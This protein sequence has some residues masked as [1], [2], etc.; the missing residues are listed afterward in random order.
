MEVNLSTAMS[1]TASASSGS[2]QGQGTS[3]ADGQTG[4]FG[5]LL[6]AAGSENTDQDEKQATDPLLALMAAL[7]GGLSPVMLLGQQFQAQM[8]SAGAEVVASAQGLF[9]N[10]TLNGNSVQLDLRNVSLNNGEFANL[11]Q[12]FGASS[13]LM[14]VLLEQPLGQPG[15]TLSAHPEL[16]ADLGKSMSQLMQTV[17]AQPQLVAAEPQ[18]AQLME[19]V[20]STLKGGQEQTSNGGG[21]MA[22]GSKGYGKMLASL[23][24]HSLQISATEQSATT[25][26][27]AANAT[28]VD[29]V[30]QHLQTG[31]MLGAEA[32]VTDAPGPN[33]DQTAPNN[34]WLSNS[35]LAATPMQAQQAMN[36]AKAEPV[37]HV[38][39]DQFHNEFAGLLVKRAAL[40]ETPGSQEFRI[41]LQPHGLGEI[42]VRVQTIGNQISLHFSADTTAAKGLLD[43]ELGSLKAQLQAQGIQFN[44]IE[45]TTSNS[46]SELAYGGMPQ[47]RG[48]SQQYQEQDGRNSKESDA[49]PFSIEALSDL[50]E[51]EPIPEEDGI[52]VSA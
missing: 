36:R 39:A 27:Q 28:Q 29:G 52:D 35:A 40:I 50:P 26:L 31:A 22:K 16:F 47:E 9:V 34:L 41:L 24:T 6:Q 33:E 13:A 42:E 38:H 23:S 45:V 2:T 12:D 48:S 3:K 14:G 51:E 43:A 25:T 21:E 32:A 37:V 8:G 1:N 20:I 10:V 17:T 46:N 44:R 19:S 15:Q 30:K 18:I 7:S 11:L 5:S 49:D 4:V